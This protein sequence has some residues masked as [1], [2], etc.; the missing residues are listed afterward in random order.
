M[1][2]SSPQLNTIVIPSAARTYFT[3]KA[4]GPDAATFTDGK[5]DIFS[6]I[7]AYSKYGSQKDMEKILGEA[8]TLYRQNPGKITYDAATNQF[9]GF[10]RGDFKGS[11]PGG[12]LSELAGARFLESPEFQEAFYKR[13]Q[14]T[15]LQEQLDRP[16]L[17][18]E[19]NI[20][21]R[22]LRQDLE[23][24]NQG[25]MNT[26]Q[27]SGSG[28]KVVIGA[29]GKPKIVNSVGGVDKNGKPVVGPLLGGGPGIQGRIDIR[30]NPLMTR[31]AVELQKANQRLIRQLKDLEGS[32]DLQNVPGGKELLTRAAITRNP[33]LNDKLSGKLGLGGEQ[34]AIRQAGEAQVAADQYKYGGGGRKATKGGQMEIDEFEQTQRESRNRNAI[35]LYNAA[36]TAYQ[37]KMDQYKWNTERRDNLRATK[38]TLELERY[39]VEEANKRAQWEYQENERQRKFREAEAEKER[40]YE[41]KNRGWGSIGN[42]FQMFYGN[43]F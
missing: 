22:T 25:D 24:L 28:A 12:F 10:E 9:T 35:N 16:M 40:L 3:E 34:R 36:N 14:K 2:S 5:K 17:D 18:A 11:L 15:H 19:G 27:L 6:R 4:Y 7:A 23:L 29:D 41:A 43:S 42:I 30:Q 38:D 37:T 31:K 20:T 33:Q 39:K 26:A 32:G 1:T 21:D 8:V 13:L